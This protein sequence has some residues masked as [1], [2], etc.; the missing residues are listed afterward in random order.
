M[1]GVQMPGSK[2]TP[3]TCI[4]CI[5]ATFRGVYHCPM[6]RLCSLYLSQIAMMGVKKVSD[7]LWEGLNKP[8][9]QLKFKKHMPLSDLQTPWLVANAPT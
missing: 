1:S 7:L 5:I 8:K 9:E 6:G 2:C 3:L 4:T